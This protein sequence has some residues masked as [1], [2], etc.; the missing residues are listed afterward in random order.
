MAQVAMLFLCSVRGMAWSG[1]SPLMATDVGSSPSES[2]TAS[3]PPFPC[4]EW[5]SD[6]LW[7]VVRDAGSEI[8]LRVSALEELIARRDPQLRGFLLDELEK[9][10][11]AALWQERL[12]FAS[13]DVDFLEEGDRA[14]L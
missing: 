10:D 1:V 2:H 13:E 7:S 6:Q 5:E 3:R 9:D 4:I 12:I 14:R 11:L 8:G